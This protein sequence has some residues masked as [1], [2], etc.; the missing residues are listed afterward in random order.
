MVGAAGFE[1]TAS[2]SQSTR[3]TKL[4]Y[5]P[6]PNQE[7]TFP[8]WVP[9]FR[10]STVLQAI[11][12]L[13]PS[14]EGLELQGANLLLAR[15][16]GHLLRS[17]ELECLEVFLDPAQYSRR[18]VMAAVADEILPPERKGKGTLRFYPI[19]SMAEVWQDA[20][21]RVLLC[22]D[23]A[24]LPRDRYLRD[25]FASGPLAISCQTH[26]MGGN[27]LYEALSRIPLDPPLPFDAITCLSRACRDFLVR[28]FDGY[29]GPPG[30]TPP[31]RLEVVPNPIEIERFEPTTANLRADA[32]RLL[33]LP[34]EGTLT[35]YLGRL[36][37][38]AKADLIPLVEQFAKVA[39]PKD[40]LLLAGVENT[41]GYAS[42][43]RTEG[44]A[45]G[46]GK[47]LIV[48][49]SVAPR[50]APLFFRCA[51]VFCFPGDS[52]QETFG[53]TLLEAMASGLPVIAS[54]W[55]GFRDMVEHGRTGY[56]VPTYLLPGLQAIEEYSAA[57]PFLDNLL[58]VSQNVVV[59]PELL[60]KAL[61]NLLQSPAQREAMG[62]AGRASVEDR[63]TW[64]SVGAKLFALWSE[65]LEAASKEPRADRERR[66]ADAPRIGVPIA[67]RHIFESY[68]TEAPTAAE[69]F[70]R[71]NEAGAAILA[72]RKKLA[73]YDET[74][75]LIRQPI[76]DGIFQLMDKD[77][78]SWLSLH[79][80]AS[81]VA[82]STGS[83]EDLV[84]Y[85]LGLLAKRGAL[86]LKSSNNK[87]TL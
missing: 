82:A 10:V 53:N 35:M 58:Q 22:V 57:V 43:L 47:R 14:I 24:L 71:L 75:P 6:K 61:S 72:G 32:R 49:T 67:F 2:C 17:P 86:D 62:R 87:L 13:S 78:T 74:L 56:L 5:A 76:V 26:G 41:P 59:Q 18:S 70:V 31:L 80:I 40:H 28:T 63:F 69:A 65:L 16:L 11:E 81:D 3:S 38:H 79:T 4:S 19:H 34:V 20:E 77:R 44:V 48:R 30:S 52:V 45:S 8:G 36:S 39:G 66:R 85:H 1:P 23:P 51:D 50:T 9:Q 27:A 12:Q 73:F 7:G 68:A 29:L 64:R 25:R 21:P 83:S 54:D 15:I 60:G 37:P 42:R 55:D 84:L 46:L 33:D